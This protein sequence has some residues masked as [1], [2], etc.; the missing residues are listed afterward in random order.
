[1]GPLGITALGLSPWEIGQ[2]SA[3]G[4]REGCCGVSE[5]SP[6]IMS[7]K[8]PWPL[9]IGRCTSYPGDGEHLPS[10]PSGGRI[11]RASDRD[12]E[13]GSQFSGWRFRNRG[14]H[15]AAGGVQPK[16]LEHSGEGA[17]TKVPTGHQPTKLP[18]SPQG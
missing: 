7:F 6:E 2:H 17:R 14:F 11:G 12:W 1:M 5:L 3:E 4:G 16:P 13:G 9:A 18:L 10:L 8:A 15:A